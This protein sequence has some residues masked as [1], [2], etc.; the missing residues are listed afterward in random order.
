MRNPQRRPVNVTSCALVCAVLGTAAGGVFGQRAFAQSFADNDA[1]PQIEAPQGTSDEE[2]GAERSETGGPSSP[3]PEESGGKKDGA[4]DGDAAKP[5]PR[6]WHADTPAA[7]KDRLRFAVMSSLGTGRGPESG[8][9]SDILG[10]SLAL[11]YVLPMDLKP[12]SQL[13][14]LGAA[15]Y[16]T[17]TGVDTKRSRDV[18]V[19]RF[20]AGGGLEVALNPRFR[21]GVLAEVG[22]FKASRADIKRSD[23]TDSSYGAHMALLPFTRWQVAPK[24]WL[25]GGAD[26]APILAYSW[27]GLNLGLSLAF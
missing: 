24:I 9:S 7:L 11:H 6:H 5:E 18:V 26:V 21:Y 25:V 3:Q 19:Q 14:W 22:M 17:H 20:L 1:P 2:G 4:A 13:L 8:F 23:A 16:A 27:Y 15:R 12:T 10:F